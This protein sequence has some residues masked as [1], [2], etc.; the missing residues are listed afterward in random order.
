M[1]VGA[2][3]LLELMNK[4]IGNFIYD[5]LQWIAKPFTP[6]GW[7][8]EFKSIQQLGAGGVLKSF[9]D[10]IPRLVLY[11]VLLAPIV[12]MPLYN[13]LL[14]HPFAAGNFDIATVNGVP[15]QNLSFPA[16]NGARLH[17][18][19]LK[20]PGAKKTIL[21]SHGNA[22]NLTDRI[23]LVSL[24]LKAG[25]SVFIYDYQGFG[26]SQGSPSLEG[27]CADGMAAYEYVVQ[28]RSVKPADI[29][30]FGES[31]GTGVACAIASEKMYG[32]IILQSPYT[33]LPTI[34]KEKLKHLQVYPDWLF[35]ATRLDNLAVLRQPHPPLLLVHGKQDQIVPIAHSLQLLNQSAEP[36]TMT[37]LPNA[38]HNDIY[39]VDS[40][41]YLQSLRMYIAS[42]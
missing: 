10:S 15:C 26:K 2:L 3:R 24:L 29:V 9:I 6:T 38:G 33:D 30:L 1:T 36:K 32:G 41:Q 25:A 34:A 42:L 21:L 7:K 4:S 40:K 12:A 35:P 13:T 22:G 11:Y 18:W 20:L 17:A 27:I 5:S 31:I 28:H 8:D 14:F 39:S 23:G 19:Y 37:L 16:P